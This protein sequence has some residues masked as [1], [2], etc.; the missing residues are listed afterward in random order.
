[1]SFYRNRK[2]LLMVIVETCLFVSSCV[3][4]LIKQFFDSF[5]FNF[6]SHQFYQR[7][8]KKAPSLLVETR[9]IVD[10]L[11]ANLLSSI[12]APPVVGNL[13]RLKV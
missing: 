5:I 6:V 11:P 13:V 3:I 12:S 9:I 7:L 2:Y 10:P 1:M 4:V 8:I